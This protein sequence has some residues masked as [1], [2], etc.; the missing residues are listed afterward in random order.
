VTTVSPEK[1]LQDSRQDARGRLIDAALEAFVEEGYRASIDRIAARAQVARQTIYNHFGSKDGLFAEVIHQASQQI[2]VTLDTEAEL[3]SAL[4]AF[5]QAYREKV[6]SPDGIA[7]FRTIAAEAP[8]FP[9]LSK[10]FF[11]IGPQSTR[12]RLSDYLARAIQKDLLRPEDP[13]FMA[14][15]LVAMLVEHER[16]QALFT[17]KQATL[18]HP[19]TT[20]IVDQF[21]R[22]FSPTKETP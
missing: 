11:Q 2:L 5:G 18:S 17:L 9:E 16:I 6:L 10:Q 22:L 15:T 1:L 21:L 19:K 3:R 8:N 20:Q 14:E 7:V 12:K 13:D 4:I